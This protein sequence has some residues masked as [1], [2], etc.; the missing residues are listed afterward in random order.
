LN[1]KEGG[2]MPLLGVNIAII[3]DGKILLTKRRD[4]EVWCLPGG[5]VDPGES[6]A[7]AA[8]REAKEEVGF[9]VKLERLVGIHSRPQWL[10]SGSHVAVFTAKIIAGDLVIQSQ[11]VLE[12]RF[13]T[14]DELPE[15]MLLGHHQQILDALGGIC[16]A[17]WTHESEWDFPPGLTRQELYQLRDRSG[18]SPSEF[19][20]QRIAK[21]VRDGHR[22]EV[23]GKDDVY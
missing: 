17:V 10:S 19:Y 13:F 11:E 18:L 22:L 23:A 12:A 14:R 8:I 2:S 5:E 6:L 7:R 9:D 4:F 16:G 21:P 15:A 20:Q 3:R 1:F